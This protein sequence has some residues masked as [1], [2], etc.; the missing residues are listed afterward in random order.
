M[1]FL[2]ASPDTYLL[3]HELLNFMLITMSTQLLS[4]PSLG[5]DNVHPFIDAAMAQVT[6]RNFPFFSSDLDLHIF[7]YYNWYIKLLVYLQES[8]LAGLV[9]RKLLV[10]FIT[11]PH[12]SV[13]RAAYNIFS[14]GNQAGV[15]QRVGSAA[16]MEMLLVLIFLP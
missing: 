12:F 11:R 3:H 14:E 7:K 2:F 1:S 13:L 5:P 8:S 4:G 6:K 9:V 10:S 16:G 15:L